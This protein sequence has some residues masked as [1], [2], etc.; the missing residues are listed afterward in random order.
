[1]GYDAYSYAVY[2]KIVKSK[3][4]EVVKPKRACNHG[5]EPEHKFCPE[6]GKP[7]YTYGET[8]LLDSMEDKG[9]SYYYSDYENK[10]E[11]VLGFILGRDGYSSRKYSP[12]VE[13][14]LP[15]PGMTEEIKKFCEENG[16]PFKDG[17]CKTWVFTYHS[18]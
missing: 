2:G 10:E 16:I 13:V 1:M 11:V 15:T 14:K 8:K 4:L 12:F 18:Y 6:C 5:V 7:T 9:L 17:D 3:S